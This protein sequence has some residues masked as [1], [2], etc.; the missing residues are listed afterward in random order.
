MNANDIET[1]GPGPE[2]PGCD[3]HAQPPHRDFTGRWVKLSTGQ[4]GLR[5]LLEVQAL[6]PAANGATLDARPSSLTSRAE[7]PPILDFIASDATLDR[8]GEVI[9]ASGWRLDQFR[10]NPV[11]QNAH[12]YGNIIHTLGRAQLAEVRGG[13]LFL[14]VLFA[15]DINPLARLA[16]DLYRRGFLHAVSVGFLPRRWENGTDRTPWRRRFLEQELLEV[17]AVAVPANPNALVLAVKSGAVER[18]ELRE[19]LAL[20]QDTLGHTPG[21][22]MRTLLQ[23]ARA[24]AKALNPGPIP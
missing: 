17:S 5:G 11:F 8:A 20:L 14:R 15:T 2:T 4:T 18:G 10:R 6:P 12:N 23:S 21:P 3:D 9:E 22:K 16:Y 13:R 24:L 1:T 19:L 7:P